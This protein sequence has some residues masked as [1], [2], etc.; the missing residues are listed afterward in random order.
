[1]ETRTSG[2]SGSKYLLLRAAM[3]AERKL[4][5]RVPGRGNSQAMALRLKVEGNG[6]VDWARH[7]RLLGQGKR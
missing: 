4:P 1:M 7:R 5:K 2:E 6:G 3:S